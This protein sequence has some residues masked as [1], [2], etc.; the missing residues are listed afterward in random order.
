MKFKALF[1]FL[2]LVIQ[3]N[4]LQVFFLKNSTYAKKNIL[5]NQNLFEIVLILDSNR[6]INVLYWLYFNVC[7][8]SVVTYHLL[9]S[10]SEKTKKAYIFNFNILILLRFKNLKFQVALKS[11]K[12]KKKMAVFTQNKFLK[13]LILLIWCNSKKNP[14]NIYSMFQKW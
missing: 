10:G 1:I 7:F 6:V 14:T 13:K 11:V 2:F 9:P 4:T 3:W 8:S 5:N 12:K